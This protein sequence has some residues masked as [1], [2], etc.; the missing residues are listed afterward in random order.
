M[1]NI[2]VP[3]NISP[4]ASNSLAEIFRI[5]GQPNRIQILLV[6][7]RQDACVCHIEAVLG[8]RQAAI[9]QHLM[10]LRKAGLVT[11]AREGRHVFYLLALP[12]L[13]PAILQMA[14]AAG[15]SAEG[16]AQFSARPLPGCSC[17]RC[18]P[19]MDPKLVCR[20]P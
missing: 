12:D 19:G 11:T 5:L 16:L 6:I 9:S 10:V 2:F 7:A 13:Y 8:I 18:N 14:A 17:P 15:I 4:E 3:A 20:K 1:Y